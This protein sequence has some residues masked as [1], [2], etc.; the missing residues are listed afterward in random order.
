MNVSVVMPAYNA[1][2]TIAA[3]LE[4]VLA[5]THPNWEVIVVDDGST[6]ATGELARRFAARD[7]RIK[8]VSQRNGGESAAR[9]T[10]VG[11][12]SYDW[13]HFLDADDWIAPTCLERLTAELAANPELDAVHCRG[14]RVAQDGTFFGENYVA[15]TGDLFPTLARRAAFPVHACVV[16]KSLVEA[17]GKFDTTLKTSPDWDLWQRIARGGARFGSVSEVLVYYRMTANSSSLGADQLFSDILTVLRRGHSRDPRV[18]KPLPEYAEGWRGATVESQEFYLLSWCAGL[19]IG[20]G[21]DAR[22]LF[23]AVKN[24]RYA[25]LSPQAIAESVFGAAIL[26][27]CQPPAAWEKLWPAIQAL[28]DQFL[29]ALEQQS[30]TPDLSSPGHA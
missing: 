21:Q 1:A 28:A 12:A 2:R 4:S 22:R 13:L 3:A 25:E 5:Q 6:D 9:N 27:S 19:L 8:V 24:D 23:E 15:P 17:V 10:G 7:A 29:V 16:R 14:V 20:Y 26:P 18:P 11:L 30:G